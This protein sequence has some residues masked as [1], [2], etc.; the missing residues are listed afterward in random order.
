MNDLE[1]IKELVEK[2]AEYTTEWSI[3]EDELY[4]NIDCVRKSNYV[5]EEHITEQEF[6]RAFREEIL[7]D[8][9]FNNG[10]A[11]KQQMENDYEVYTEDDELFRNASVKLE[12]EIREFL[13]NFKLKR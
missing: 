6:Q 12:K 2:I 8:L 3:T 13:P 5:K 4:W 1:M 7:Y 10:I 9:I 11:L